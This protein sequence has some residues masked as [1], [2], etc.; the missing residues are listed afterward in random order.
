[1][2]KA[3]FGNTGTTKKKRLQQIN[4]CLLSQITDKSQYNDREKQ[5]NN[6]S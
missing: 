6:Y 2:T 4:V 3:G 5:I 1:M